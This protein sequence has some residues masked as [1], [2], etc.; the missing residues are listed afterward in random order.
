MRKA[1]GYAARAIDRRPC[2]RTNTDIEDPCAPANCAMDTARAM[3]ARDVTYALRRHRGLR[4]DEAKLVRLMQHRTG[5]CL[6]HW[7][8]RG[9]LPSSR[10]PGPK[11]ALPWEIEAKPQTA[12]A[13]DLLILS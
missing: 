3:R 9:Y 6:G 2:F 5:T 10:G 13:Y 12:P 8:R 11:G 4:T 1:F 7:W